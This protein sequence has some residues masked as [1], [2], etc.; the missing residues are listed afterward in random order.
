MACAG[1]DGNGIVLFVPPVGYAIDAIQC[2]VRPNET[3][4][5][6]ESFCCAYGE[7]VKEQF[8]STETK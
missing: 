6:P 8:K 2:V 5:I 3:V 7:D 4:N 1:D